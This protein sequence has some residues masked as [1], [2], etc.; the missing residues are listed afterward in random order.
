MK[1]MIL[2]ILFATLMGSFLIQGVSIQA[3]YAGN[4]KEIVQARCTVC[5]DTGRIERAGHDRAGWQG[6]V[7]RMMGKRNFGPKLS[8][9]E[10]EALI[11]HLVSL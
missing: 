6:T 9:A 7:D 10:Y 3:P 2:T 11:E 8:D 5:H 1:K 4:G